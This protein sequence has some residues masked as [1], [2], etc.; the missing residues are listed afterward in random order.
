MVLIHTA[1]Y[2][3]SGRISNRQNYRNKFGV[4]R[5]ISK[6]IATI[7][8]H[9]NLSISTQYNRGLQNSR[10][11]RP[12]KLNTVE[13]LNALGNVIPDVLNTYKGNEYIDVFGQERIIEYT[14]TSGH[15]YKKAIVTSLYVNNQCLLKT[16]YRL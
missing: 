12:N 4:N 13:V 7:D 8:S 5:N 14:E 2:D 10:S 6:K 9:C 11:F 1:W 15:I 3:I 16:S